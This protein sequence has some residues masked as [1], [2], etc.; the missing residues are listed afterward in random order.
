[1]TSVR[2]VAA[3]ACAT[4]CVHGGHARSAGHAG[5]ALIAD[6]ID[7]LVVYAV[8]SAQ[9]AGDD[10]EQDET[11]IP[12]HLDHALVAYAIDDVRPG[13]ARCAGDATV[14]IAVTVRPG[15]DIEHLFITAAPPVQ[16]CVAA[17][18][19]DVRFARTLRGGSFHYV[20]RSAPR[21]GDA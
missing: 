21:P 8:D 12:D 6:V 3:I 10:E 18:V 19:S 13:L 4:G 1:M 9:P 17:L 16:E 5:A 15:G 7:S 14:T 11:V 20:I 2:F